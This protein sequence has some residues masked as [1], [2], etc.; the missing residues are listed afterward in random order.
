MITKSMIKSTIEKKPPPFYSQSYPK[1][2][3]RYQ[4]QS[5]SIQL[6]NNL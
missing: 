3:L 5:M 6:V 1:N 4:N 2:L